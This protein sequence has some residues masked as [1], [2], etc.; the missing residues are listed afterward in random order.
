MNNLIGIYNNDRTKK[1]LFSRFLFK[2]TETPLTENVL[3]N[4]Q[5]QSKIK[6][7]YCKT[8]KN[9]FVFK[10]TKF[11]KNYEFD[12][13]FSD[14][15]CA[16]CQTVYRFKNKLEPKPVFDHKNPYMDLFMKK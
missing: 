16:V 9:G 3:F 14:V 8:C 2:K 13:S 15:G 11:V 1:D 7:C 10:E 5:L 6:K 12:Q 4:E